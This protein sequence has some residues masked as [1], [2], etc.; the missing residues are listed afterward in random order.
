MNVE[1]FLNELS[2]I[3]N[4]NTNVRANEKE[5]LKMGIKDQGRN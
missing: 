3:V 1:E 2:I 4:S 5:L